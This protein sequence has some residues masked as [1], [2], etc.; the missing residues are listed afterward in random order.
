MVVSQYKL[1][2]WHV[3][4][5]QLEAALARFAAGIKVVD[6]MIAKGLNA[7]QSKRQ[8]AILVSRLQFCRA[9][10]ATGDWDSLLKVDAALLPDLLTVRATLMASDGKEAEVAQAG[11]KLRELEPKTEI[12]LYN[13]ACAFGLCAGLAANGKPKP[14]EAEARKYQDLAIACL[15]EAIAAGYKDFDHMRQDDDLK[16]LRSLPEF[17]SLFPK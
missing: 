6:D 13:A 1:G 7:E 16:P 9:K 5:N 14:D 10:L 2:E 12:N 11:A 4:A 17:E 3:K 15:K 8:K